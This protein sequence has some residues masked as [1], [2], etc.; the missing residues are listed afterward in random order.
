[1][2]KHYTDRERLDYVKKFKQSGLMLSEFASLEKINRSTLSDWIKAYD[3]IEGHFIR[4]DQLEDTPGAL[5]HEE[6]IRV[7][8]LRGNRN[9]SKVK[10][11]FKI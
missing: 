2:K 8:M 5:I 7:N 3:H 9:H 1:M 4:I 11:F 6:N 10:S